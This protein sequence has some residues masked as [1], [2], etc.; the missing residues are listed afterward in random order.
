MSS[1]HQT[2]LTSGNRIYLYRLLR[3]ALGI[4]KQTFITQVD[5][6][7]EA[8]GLA[9]RGLGY[10]DTRALLEALNEFTTLTVFKGGRVYVTL[11]AQPEW[12]EALDTAENDSAKTANAKGGKGG[13]PWKRKR[14]ARPIKAVKPRMA[15]PDEPMADDALVAKGRSGTAASGGA[16]NGSTSDGSSGATASGGDGAAAAP[17]GHGS[18]AGSDGESDAS[19]PTG[20]ESP[21]STEPEIDSVTA[22]NAAP[23]PVDS[24]A[25]ETQG[26]PAGSHADDNAEVLPADN[27]TATSATGPVHA[28]EAVQAANSS[29]AAAPV[30]T[31]AY[32]FTVTF[33]PDHTDAG[34][35]TLAST[36]GIDVPTPTED[37]AASSSPAES[38]A[39]PSSPIDIASSVPVSARSAA[40]DSA[41]TESAATT[42]ASSGNTARSLPSPSNASS[43]AAPAV[44]APPS[45]ER[46]HSASPTAASAG[47][48]SPTSGPAGNASPVSASAPHVDLSAYPQ[49]F[50]TDVYC[51]ARVMSELARLLPYG[52]DA[53]A[54]AGEYFYIACERGTA[55]LGRGRASFPLRYLQDGTRHVATVT[56]KKRPHADPVWAIESVTTSEGDR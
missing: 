29:R 46:A 41:S 23:E 24:A 16:G 43:T 48:V 38:D 52:A 50:S 36:P 2:Q 34:V 31:P 6:A 54:I 40:A 9:A 25:A 37:S 22:P 18:S 15:A 3:N 4:G 14:G 44:T 56:I 28:E 8:D 10:P 5:E 20:S 27:K 33:D 55:D 47:I 11:S 13:K 30:R 39:T 7:L 21:S 35:T 32:S 51:S 17:N 45:S 42:P 12:D 26:S 49:D 1:H 53:L 19:T